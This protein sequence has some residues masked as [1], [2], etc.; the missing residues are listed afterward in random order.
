M[1]RLLLIEKF[2]KEFGTEAMDGKGVSEKVVNK[3]KVEAPSE[4]LV[5]GYLTEI[6][7]TYGVEWPRSDPN[8]KPPPND[9]DDDD[10]PGGQKVRLLEPELPADELSHATPPKSL[11]PKSPVQIAP[12]SP[13][14][15]NPSPT[16]KLPGPPDL[17]PG[18]K[19]VSKKADMGP[20]GGKIPD[21]D[22]LAK[23]FAALKR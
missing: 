18:G 3:L 9:E 7:R 15:E 14:T 4:E 23:R 1:A 13:S 11:G 19:M 5:K 10:A 22:E 17:K 2:G 16:I 20:V 6:A 8:K 12:P 21:V